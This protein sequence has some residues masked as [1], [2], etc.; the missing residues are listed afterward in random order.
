ME[1]IN[2]LLGTHFQQIISPGQ[3]VEA[4]MINGLGL[5]STPLYLFEKF[6]VGKTTEHLL[7]EGISPEHLNDDC[8]GRVLD[9]LH[10]AGLTQVFVSV[11]LQA[12]RKFGVK[13]D[14]L[15]LDFSSF[16]VHREYASSKKEAIAI[17][18]TYGYSRD[19]RPNLKQFIGD[20][21]C[22]GDG[23]ISLSLRV[24]DGN[25]SDCAMFA[26]ILKEFRQQWQIEALFVADAALYTE[27]N[28]QQINAF[29]ALAITNAC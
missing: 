16:D 12:A 25:E 26:Q 9:K 5:V 8:L 20:L 28:I 15:H 1:Q 11:A 19:H 3:A 7:G 10:Q 17:E 2:K 29:L 18:I 21:I 4:M 23:D 27:E 6:F 22:S 13:M 24:A 14:S